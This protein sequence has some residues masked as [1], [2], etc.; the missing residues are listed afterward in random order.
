MGED[1]SQILQER[2]MG[3]ITLYTSTV[4]DASIGGH[5]IL[6]EPIAVKQIIGVVPHELALGED[7]TA[8]ESLLLGVGVRL[9]QQFPQQPRG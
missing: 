4:G 9:E 5:S 8:R 6:K 1:R 2:F 3:S 7:L